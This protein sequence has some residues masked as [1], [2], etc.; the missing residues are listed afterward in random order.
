MNE[1]LI[2]MDFLKSKILKEIVV[3]KW[4]ND[5]IYFIT[6]NDEVIKMYHEQDCCESVEIEEII[7]DLKDLINSP[8]LMSECETNYVKNS[9]ESKTWTFYKL[10]TIKGYVT[11]RWCGK[12]NGYY[13]EEVDLKLLGYLPDLTNTSIYDRIVL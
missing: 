9:F 2:E 12:S 1:K 4:N 8:I 10:A 13:S 6:D 3:D 11:I 7:G 5:K